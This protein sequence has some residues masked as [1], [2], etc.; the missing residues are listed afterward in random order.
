MPLRGNLFLQRVF[1]IFSQIEEAKFQA[2]TSSNCIANVHYL[3][4]K[5]ESDLKAR[6][7]IKV[8]I[9]HVGVIGISYDD[10]QRALDS[11]FKDFEDALQFY[12]ALRHGCQ[13]IITRNGKDYTQATIDVYSPHEFLT[14]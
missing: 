4:K 1:N 13:A 6:Q 3:L 14:L 10:V 7:F 2:F 9:A 11:E 8:I 5:K 12:S